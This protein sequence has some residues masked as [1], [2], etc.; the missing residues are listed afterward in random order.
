MNPL[1]EIK[2]LTIRFPEEDKNFEA[3]KNVSFQIQEGEIVGIVGESGSGKSMSALALMGLLKEQAQIS[4]GEILFRGKDLLKMGKEERRNLQGNE[5]AMVFQEPMTSLNPVIK[6]E[7]QVAET[8]RLHTKLSKEEIHK[9]VLAALEEV[10]L[11][12]AEALCKKYPHELSGGMRQ[13]VMLAQAAICSPSLLI[14]DEPTTALDVVVQAQILQLL[15]KFHQEKNTSILFISHDL[16]VIK[17]LC[18]RV[19]VMYH[20]EIVEEGNTKEV[21][22]H[23]KHEYTKHLVASFPKKNETV[24]SDK[25]ILSLKNLNVYYDI[26]EGIFAKKGKKHV[27]HDLNFD[28]YDGE[29][30]GIVGESGCG[31][32]TLCKTILNLHDNYTGTI[33]RQE[34]LFTQMVFQDPYSSLNPSK[35]VGWILEEPLRLRGVKDK[36]KRKEMVF[37][38][39]ESIGLDASFAKRKPAELSGGQRQ[40]ISIGTALMMDSRLL[41]ADEPVSALDVTVQSQILNLLLKLH[42]EKKMTILFISHDL[43]VIRSICQRVIVLYKGKIVE[44][45]TAKE[46]YENPTHPYTKQLLAAA[47]GENQESQESLIDF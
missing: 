34:Q 21:L 23:P 33:Q 41:I 3:V 15:K 11:I 28:V 24:I 19:I 25:K 40:R 32:S 14:A 27:L 16:N 47:I 8:L 39:L 26:K 38:M 22:V 4:S 5:M 29:I 30:L 17:E 36:K 37:S 20:G 2:N 10:G 44:E 1:V 42:E 6:I 35:N 12:D 7:K 46:I 45:G 9:K 18:S 43:N 13:R 31:K